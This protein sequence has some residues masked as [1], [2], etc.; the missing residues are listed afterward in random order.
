MAEKKAFY[1]NNATAVLGNFRYSLIKKAIS[2]P[3]LRQRNFAIRRTIF[4]IKYFSRRM[5]S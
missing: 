3:W 4:A 5:T 1:S 2:R